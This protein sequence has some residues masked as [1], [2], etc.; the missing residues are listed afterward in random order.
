ML[1]LISGYL[2]QFSQNFAK[3]KVALE[4]LGAVN[5]VMFQ[6]FNATIGMHE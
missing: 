5:D 2:L 6:C 3:R 4:N 1:F